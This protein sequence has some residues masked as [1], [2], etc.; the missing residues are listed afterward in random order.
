MR[1]CLLVWPHFPG[2]VCQLQLRHFHTLM[3]PPHDSPWH[4]F[5][6]LLEMHKSCALFQVQ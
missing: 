5:E 4:D 6:V 1:L 2:E 3:L